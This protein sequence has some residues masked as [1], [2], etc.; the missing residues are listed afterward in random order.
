MKFFFVIK[1]KNCN[2]FES[3]A[4][5]ICTDVSEERL[6]TC[7]RKFTMFSCSSSYCFQLDE[8]LLHM[9]CLNI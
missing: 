1:F 2:N 8:C 3:Y 4:W 9:K 7:I 6:Y 5:Q